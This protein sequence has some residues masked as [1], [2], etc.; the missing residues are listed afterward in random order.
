MSEFITGVENDLSK[1]YQKLEHVGHGLLDDVEELVKHP[2]NTIERAGKRVMNALREGTNYVEDKTE[3]MYHALRNDLSNVNFKG[4]E[5]ELSHDLKYAEYTADHLYNKL[6]SDADRVGMR[7]E[8]DVNELEVQL[9]NGYHNL[10][11]VNT[12]RQVLPT[13]NSNRSNIGMAQNVSQSM[14]DSTMNL[15]EKL[16]SLPSESTGS[17]TSTMSKLRMYSKLFLK[18]IIVVLVI[19]LLCALLYLTL[20]RYL[21]VGTALNNNNNMMAAALLTPEL[22]A[23]LTTLAAVL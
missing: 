13:C 6:K 21:L 1:S 5:N 9:E 8:Q 12:S 19:A 17:S 22:S 11:K 7:L 14:Y 3:S 23:G 10:N 16:V 18:N 2:V 15:D 4:Y 20:K